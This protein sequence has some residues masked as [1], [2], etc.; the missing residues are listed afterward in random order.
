MTYIIYKDYIM[1]KLYNSETSSKKKN[2][3]LNQLPGSGPTQPV[4][5]VPNTG[6][7]GAPRPTLTTGQTGPRTGQTG[8]DRTEGCTLSPRGCNPVSIHH[9]P[10]LCIS[11]DKLDAAGAEIHVG[12]P[13]IKCS[14]NKP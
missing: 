3:Q 9:F 11:A 12:C 14:G 7:T 13:E 8:P 4:R 10:P 1:F 5:P 2:L 6:Q